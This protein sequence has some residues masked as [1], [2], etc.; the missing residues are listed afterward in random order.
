MS[1]HGTTA[2]LRMV[3][4]GFLPVLAI[5][6]VPSDLLGLSSLHERTR[7]VLRFALH[8]KPVPR[9]LL[10]PPLPRVAGLAFDLQNVDRKVSGEP[11][12][13]HVLRTVVHTAEAMERLDDLSPSDRRVLLATAYLH[14]SLELQRKNNRP[15]GEDELLHDVLDIFP[16]REEAAR[17]VSLVSALTPPRDGVSFSDDREYLQYKV[18]TFQ[19]KLRSNHPDR[20]LLR[21]VKAA[22][23]LANM[24]ETTD[25]I[26]RG[27]DDARMGRGYGLRVWIF[28]TCTWALRLHDRTNPLLPELEHELLYLEGLEKQRLKVL[29]RESMA[30]EL[31]AEPAL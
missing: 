31:T 5:D 26:E 2:R 24:E 23:M 3:P 12:F 21:I 8:D 14:D 19:E 1:E 6:T 10:E 7:P 11:Y 17:I 25:D 15:Y 27:L 30:W 22:D 13:K 4:D 9:A 18:R 20:R 28:R 16:D 29:D